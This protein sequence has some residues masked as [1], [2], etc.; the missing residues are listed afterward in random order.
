[1]EPATVAADFLLA[2]AELLGFGNR[3]E[4]MR[5]ILRSACGGRLTGR[6]ADGFPTSTLSVTGIPF[7]AS[8]TGGRGR[9]H[10]VLR[11]V[12]EAGTQHPDFG[13]RLTAQV[14]AIDAVTAAIPNIVAAEAAGLRSFVTALYPNP[15]AVG[16]RH[17]FATWL[18]IAHHGDGPESRVGVKLYGSLLAVPDGLLRLR[19]TFPEFAESILVPARDAFVEPYFAAIEIDSNGGFAHKV[20]FRARYDDAATPMKLVRHFGDPAW[21]V[22]SEV[23]RCGADAATLHQFPI[24]ICTG[25]RGDEPIFALHL[26]PH[27]GGDLTPLVH[28]LAVR[29]HGGTAALDALTSASES[30]GA[31]WRYSV[32]GL[33][34]SPDGGIRN[35]N[36]YGTPIWDAA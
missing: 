18:G 27:R 20:Y 32:V 21:E 26:G 11:Y 16:T 35:V 6:A 8:V 1:M 29:H 25:R 19:A 14:A 17:G 12:V 7:E 13:S 4:P 9:V 31:S 33:G 23:V 22:L 2:A 15:A 3:P 36:V 24:V 5:A 30:V 10:P 28:A 34:C